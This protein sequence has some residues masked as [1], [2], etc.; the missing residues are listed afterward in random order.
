M[1]LSTVAKKEIA[2]CQNGTLSVNKFV[3]TNCALFS[4]LDVPLMRRFFCSN[5][6]SLS[7][8]SL[9]TLDVIFSTASKVVN[10]KEGRTSRI[11]AK[12]VATEE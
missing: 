11:L 4:A 5:S 8:L 10:F 2:L 7:Q 1:L 6:H 12:L 3:F 9:F